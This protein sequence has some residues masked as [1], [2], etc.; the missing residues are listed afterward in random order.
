MEKQVVNR[1]AVAL[2]QY[3]QNLESLLMSE[4]HSLEPP[5][6]AWGKRPSPQ[7]YRYHWTGLFPT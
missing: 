2:E 3:L 1:G 4:G 6:S 7:N 5:I